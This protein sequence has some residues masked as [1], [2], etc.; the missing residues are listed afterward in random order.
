MP[1]VLVTGAGRGLGLEFT[2]QYSA[3]GWNVLACVRDPGK[4]AELTTLAAGS[5]GRVEILPLD[6]G[7]FATID[8]LAKQT[9][10]RSIDVLI[11]NA[12]TM[13]AR[14]FA[15]EGL[16]VG[17]FGASNFDEW[18]EIFRINTFAPM[19][20]AEAFVDHLARGEQ[21]KL[22][23]LTS[24][25][26]SIGQNNLGGLYAYRASKAALNAIARSLGVDLQRKYGITAVVIHPGWVRTDMGGERADIDGATSVAG[27]RQVIAGLDKSKAG[28]FWMYDGSEL[29]W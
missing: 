27:I 10:G 13:G 28:R 7:D 2:R 16:A 9:A 15:R 24:V 12:G 20:M 19:K 18:A 21:K 29:P 4:S 11:N 3:D 8:A 6:V 26:S 5:A 23:S 1:T 17:K 25:L 22:V 14:S